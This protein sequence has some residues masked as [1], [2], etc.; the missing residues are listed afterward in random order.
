MDRPSSAGLRQLLLF[1]SDSGHDLS[2][3][4]SQ[5]LNVRTAILIT[6]RTKSVLK[7]YFL[8]IRREE[9]ESKI[10][11]YQNYVYLNF[12]ININFMKHN[13]QPIVQIIFFGRVPFVELI[14]KH[15]SIT[16]FQKSL[17]DAKS[18]PVKMVDISIQK[19]I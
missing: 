14:N 12:I 2:C 6:N 7:I 13:T 4:G 9:F 11:I 19:S 1:I 18:R 8:I 5:Y 16:H 17:Q 15:I 3:S 10:R